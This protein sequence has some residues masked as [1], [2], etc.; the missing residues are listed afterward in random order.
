M[1]NGQPNIV[2][3][4]NVLIRMEALEECDKEEKEGRD[5]KKEKKGENEGTKEH[6]SEDNE[7]M[8]G[9]SKLRQT[10]MDGS[11][12]G[13]DEFHGNWRKIRE[14]ARRGDADVEEDVGMKGEKDVNE[15]EAT[16]VEDEF[17]V[18]TTTEHMRSRWVSLVDDESIP[19]PV[20]LVDLLYNEGCISFRHKQQIEQQPT[21][22]L[23]NIEMFQ[24]IRNG[25]I[26]TFNLAKNYFRRTEQWNV[27]KMMNKQYC[28]EGEI[29]NMLITTI[30]HRGSRG[31][32]DYQIVSDRNSAFNKRILISRCFE[33][34]CS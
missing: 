28:S 14:G 34:I 15:K 33:D 4:M 18:G 11:N 6:K 29:I 8:K 25:S 1:T 19:D 32:G 17:E 7:G 31:V 3:E 24:L 2:K 12:Q 30:E 16:S 5:E 9:E 21:Q 20:N 26:K 10:A 23:Q 22:Q 13:I 27:F